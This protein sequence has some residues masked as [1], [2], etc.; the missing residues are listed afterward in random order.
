MGLRSDLRGMTTISTF[1]LQELVR[2]RR[3]GAGARDVARMLE[4]SPNTERAYR[5]LFEAS[6]VLH[7][8]PRDL[9]DVEALRSIVD[10]L[11]IAEASERHRRTVER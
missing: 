7:G 1:R 9:P 2:L 10:A 5:R 4:M 3:L 6:G 8:D 11:R